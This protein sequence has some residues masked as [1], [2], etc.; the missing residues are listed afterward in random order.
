MATYILLLISLSA[1]STILSKILQVV[2][3]NILFLIFS[4]SLHHFH[5]L[6]IIIYSMS[7]YIEI[8]NEINKVAPEV[9]DV[10]EKELLSQRS[11]LKMIASENYCSPAVM[12]CQATILTDKYSEG[13]VTTKNS[14]TESHRYYAGCDNID[15]LELL[16]QKYACELFGADHAYLQPTTGSECN[17][18]AYWAILKAKIID[19]YFELIKN[20]YNEEN[21][22]IKGVDFDINEVPKTYS[23]L[24]RAQW[25]VIREEAHKQKLLAMDYTCGGHLT[26]GYR[27]NISAQMFDVYTYGVGSDGFIDYVALE[28]Q[29]MEVKPLILLA[30]Y[31]AYPRKVDFKKFRKI[32][33]KCGAVLMVDMAHFAGLVAGKVF[34]DNYDP[35]PYADIVTMTT[36]KTFRGPRGGMIL[37]KKW[38]APYVDNSCPTCMGGQLPQVLAAK[39]VALKEAMSDDYKEYAQQIVKNAKTLADTLIELGFDVVTGGTDNH[40]VLL[41]VS[42]LGLN[43]R[44]AEWLLRECHITCNRNA[45]PKDPN[46]PWYTSGIRLGVAALT[47]LGMKETEMQFIAMTIAQILGIDTVDTQ[48]RQILEQKIWKPLVLK[49]GE[50]SKNKVDISV[51]SKNLNCIAVETLL[52]KFTCYPDL[53]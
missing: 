31:S 53:I 7:M 3:L 24:S 11:Y 8:L 22:K 45:L 17:L 16:G 4:F 47:T 20:S 52:K 51:V 35:I 2:I 12:A 25:D 19:P 23:D 10:I 38:I 39:V 40:I 36:H 21:C 27:Q 26:H 14:K 1:M 46:G 5:K 44:Q 37:C 6:N 41:D 32:A 18:M 13:Y 30:G 33:D 50:V 48:G 9:G 49:N 29:A 15:E 43:G 28:K 42:K 34:T